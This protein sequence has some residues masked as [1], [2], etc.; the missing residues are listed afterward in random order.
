MPPRRR[1]RIVRV[2]WRKKDL[3]GIQKD[4][5]KHAEGNMPRLRRA[6]PGLFKKEGT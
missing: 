5:R 2:T 4:Q 3:K 6:F 1:T